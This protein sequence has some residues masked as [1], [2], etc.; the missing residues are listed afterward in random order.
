MPVSGAKVTI[1]GPG[2]FVRSTTTGTFGFY[3]FENIAPGQTYTISVLSRRYTFTP[4]T[5]QINGN[6][7][8]VNFSAP[9]Q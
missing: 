7:T 3:A 6:L 8:G 2:N 5:M 4:Q 1:T 9:V